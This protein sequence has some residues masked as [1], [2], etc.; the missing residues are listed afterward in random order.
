MTASR[1]E[2]VRYMVDTCSFTELRRVYPRPHFD[3][4]WK[5]LEQLAQDGRLLS[6]EEVLCELKAQ[7]DEVTKWAQSRESIFLPLDEAVQRGA[8]DVL[9]R[10]PTLL[11]LKRGKSSADPFLIAAAAL[12][13][14]TVVTQEKP[15]GGPSA[16][17]IPDVCKALKI[18]CIQLLDLLKAESLAT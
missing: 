8:R 14:A 13:R 7:D 3:A 9:A 1:Q 6:V 11:D 2:P 15:S 4:V 12:Q 5:L 17:K 16:V 10:F 18:P